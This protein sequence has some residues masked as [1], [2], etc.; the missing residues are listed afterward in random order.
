MSKNPPTEELTIKEAKEIG[1]RIK[2]LRKGEFGL[3]LEDL[4][5][6]IGVSYNTMCCIEHGIGQKGKAYF[7]TAD[8]LMKLCRVLNTTPN[9]ILLKMESQNN[10]ID[11]LKRELAAVKDHNKTLKKLKGI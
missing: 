5:K 9:Y 8:I 2:L 10:K 1:E 11:S 3:N 7:F 4:A 6:V